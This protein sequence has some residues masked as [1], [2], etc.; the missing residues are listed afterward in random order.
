MNNSVWGNDKATVQLLKQ[1]RPYG[2]WLDLAAGDGR[3]IPELLKT[4]DS[5]VVSDIDQELLN[6]IVSRYEHLEVKMFDLTKRFPFENGSFDGVFCTGTLHLFRE[7]M[8]RTIFS[9]I[10]RIL[11][12]EGV[13]IFDFATNVIR[14]KPDG[15]PVVF[16]GEPKYETKEAKH[17]LQKLLFDYSLEMKESTFKDDLTNVPGHGYVIRGDFIFVVANSSRTPEPNSG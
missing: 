3:Y 17:L 12:P 8:L 15:T 11:K 4:V 13:F 9:E 1:V 16:D 10:S 14:N 5:L 2:K 7:E 6:F